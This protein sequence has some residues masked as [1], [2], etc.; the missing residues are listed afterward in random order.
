MKKHHVV[1]V[2]GG[3]SGLGAAF[4]L[5]RKFSERSLPV[6]ITVL[7]AKD[8]FGGVLR[9]FAHEGFLMEAGADAFYAGRGETGDLCRALGLEP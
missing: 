1:I 7:E 8:R 6:R 4:F 9:T 5:S 2:G 3:I